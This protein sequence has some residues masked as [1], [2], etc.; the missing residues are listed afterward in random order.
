VDL[1]AWCKDAHRPGAQEAGEAWGHVRS[2]VV[3]VLVAA[4]LGA[5]TEV[6]V[7]DLAVQASTAQA[8]ST[9]AQV[10]SATVLSLFVTAPCSSSSS[11]WELNRS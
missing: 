11:L 5:Q 8:Q 4:C 9:P 1:A 3:W 6:T 10:Q 2:W 7:N